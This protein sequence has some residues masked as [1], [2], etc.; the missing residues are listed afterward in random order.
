[1]MGRQAVARHR[2]TFQLHCLTRILGSL[3]FL[4]ATYLSDTYPLRVLLCVQSIMLQ[5]TCVRDMF[6]VI[7][8]VGP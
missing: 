5:P 8:P 6:H 7:P 3:V 1:M 2:E 4:A